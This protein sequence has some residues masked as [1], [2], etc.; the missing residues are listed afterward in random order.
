VGR[1]RAAEQTQHQAKVQVCNSLL[2]QVLVE[3]VGRPVV[4]WTALTSEGCSSHCAV[5]DCG[6]QQHSG[7]HS[8]EPGGGLVL[9]AWD[10]S[11]EACG[12][13][14]L[15]CELERPQAMLLASGRVGRRPADSACRDS[16]GGLG[17]EIHK[18]RDSIWG[19]C[20]TAGGRE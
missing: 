11:Q 16:I 1:G 13:E 9:A 17:V 6:R 10:G 12:L 14:C 4:V 15:G 20:V 3:W 7:A 2:M 8:Q 5:A 19:A 18:G